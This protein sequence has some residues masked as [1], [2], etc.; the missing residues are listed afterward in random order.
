M[1]KYSI[2]SYRKFIIERKKMN[3]NERK[4]KKED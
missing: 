4:Y 3:E 1:S 2:I